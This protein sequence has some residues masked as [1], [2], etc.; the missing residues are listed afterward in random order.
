MTLSSTS[1]L[2]MTPTTVSL[3][4]VSWPPSMSPMPVAASIAAAPDFAP[5]FGEMICMVLR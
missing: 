3:C 4:V 1:G 2:L 5:L